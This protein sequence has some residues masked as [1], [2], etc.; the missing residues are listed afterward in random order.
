ME[1]EYKMKN[2]IL[3]LMAGVFVSC[4]TTQKSAS[5]PLSQQEPSYYVV[6]DF[7]NIV[8]DHVVD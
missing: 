6:V 2:I 4:T 3:L 1:E 5:D 7:K 8:H